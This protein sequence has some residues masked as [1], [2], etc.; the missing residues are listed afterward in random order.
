VDRISSSALVAYLCD[1]E[2]R[3]WADYSRGKAI[4]APQIARLLRPF[5][6]TPRQIREG[7]ETH[8]GYYLSHFSDAFTRYLPPK[9]PKRTSS[10]EGSASVVEPKRVLLVSPQSPLRTPRGEGD[11]SAVSPAPGP[12]SRKI[13]KNASLDELQAWFRSNYRWQQQQRR[14]PR[15]DT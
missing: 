7:L 6:I 12:P 14:S 2:G 5:R 3:P 1:L 11:V 9:R 4:T 15:R 13:A 8:K 10:D